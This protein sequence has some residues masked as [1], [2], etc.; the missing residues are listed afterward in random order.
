MYYI[1][2]IEGIKIGCTVDIPHRMRE[3]GFTQWEILET[4][5]DIYEVSD[6]EIELQKQYGLPIDTIPY[7]KAVEN[8]PKWNNETRHEFTSE[9]CSIGGKKGGVIGGA[10]SKSTHQKSRRR[11]TETQIQEIKDKYI[12]RK[13]SMHKLAKEYS[14]TYTAIY[15]IIKNKTYYTK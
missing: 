14:V 5:T 7:W 1:Y 12:P 11:F 8:R 15:K 9:E 6:R 13:Y 4:H 2:H 10:K 3:Q